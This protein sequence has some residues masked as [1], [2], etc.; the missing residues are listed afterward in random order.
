[1]RITRDIH[2]WVWIACASNTLLWICACITC[3]ISTL[4]IHMWI[5]NVCHHSCANHA[6]IRA[7]VWIAYDINTFLWICACIT[8]AIKTRFIHMWINNVCHQRITHSYV[9]LQR[10]TS[11]HYS[12]ICE[13][14]TCDINTW[15][16]VCARITCDISTL[17]MY[18]SRV[19][20]THY[21]KYVNEHRVTSTH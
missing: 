19:K 21:C 5:N 18:E 12:S 11:T 9:K 3:D 4:F 16:W 8:C 7:L 15:L 1:M 6:W 2:T 13:S 17:V 10:V 20:S 14:T